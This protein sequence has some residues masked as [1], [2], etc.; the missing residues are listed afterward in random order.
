MLAP[1]GSGQL[2]FP[3]PPPHHS[4]ARFDEPMGQ[5]ASAVTIRLLH[6][7]SEGLHKGD[8]VVLDDRGATLMRPLSADD[9]PA[10][11]RDLL[12]VMTSPPAA[13]LAPASRTRNGDA[14][15]P[16]VH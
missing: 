8:T 11:I 5:T 14:R 10:E 13:S 2:S 9:L 12:P 3:K 15:P 6:D 16:I 7:Y 4:P 1:N